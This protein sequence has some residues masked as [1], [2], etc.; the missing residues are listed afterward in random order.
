MFTQY[1]NVYTILNIYTVQICLHNSKMLVTILWMYT[2]NLPFYQW[3]MRPFL[4][5]MI[6]ILNSAVFYDSVVH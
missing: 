1:Q 3:M 5:L 2:D 4:S 6:G